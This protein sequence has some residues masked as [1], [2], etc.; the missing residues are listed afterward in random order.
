MRVCVRRGHNQ[1]LMAS[2]S[3]HQIRK[4]SS[5]LSA[6]LTVEGINLAPPIPNCSQDST[7]PMVAVVKYIQVQIHPTGPLTRFP[8]I[9]RKRISKVIPNAMERNDRATFHCGEVWP[10]RVSV[11]SS[12]ME[13]EMKKAKKGAARDRYRLGMNRIGAVNACCEQKSARG[14]WVSIRLVSFHERGSNPTHSKDLR[15]THALPPSQISQTPPNRLQPP[16]SQPYSPD[17]TSSPKTPTSSSISTADSSTS[18]IPT[19]EYGR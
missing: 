17:A 8:V 11:P 9:R 7:R 4:G 15:S 16:H 14:R 1:R 3:K 2:L 6:R 13:A 10:T 5:T 12:C 19:R 18:A